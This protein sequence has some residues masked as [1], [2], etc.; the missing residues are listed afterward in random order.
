[1]L[2]DFCN[3]VGRESITLNT[4]H[5]RTWFRNVFT[6]AE[7]SLGQCEDPTAPLVP[8]ATECVA[9]PSDSCTSGSEGNLQSNEES[10][11]PRALAMLSVLLAI[12]ALAFY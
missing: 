1:M 8:G 10:S 4:P 2:Q 12:L 11:A 6:E 3:I 7:G 5:Q 9:L